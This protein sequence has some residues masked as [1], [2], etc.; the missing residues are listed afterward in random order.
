[1]VISNYLRILTGIQIRVEKIIQSKHS[2]HCEIVSLI[3]NHPLACRSGFP[4]A[5]GHVASL[6]KDKQHLLS[7]TLPLECDPEKDR[8]VSYRGILV[9]FHFPTTFLGNCQ[10]TIILFITAEHHGTL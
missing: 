8:T 4:L 7:L 9:G 2:Q 6:L 1:M 10:K 5:P 3:S